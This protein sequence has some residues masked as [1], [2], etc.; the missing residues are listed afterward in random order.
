MWSGGTRLVLKVG[1]TK[2]AAMCVALQLAA[3]AGQIDGEQ[4]AEEGDSLTATAL[5]GHDAVVTASSGL[6][7]RS[8]PSTSN[9]VLLTMPHGAV[10]SV[11]DAQGAWYKVD[12]HGSVGWASASYLAE[13][14]GATPPSTSPSADA[15]AILDRARSGVGFSYHWGAGCWSPGSASP[16]ACYG[17][18]PNC[19][20]S[21]TWGADCS[22]FV[23]KAWQVPGA[24]SLET[25]QHPYSTVNFQNDRSHWSA[26]S[27]GSVKGADAF[28]YNANGAG[29]I[30]LYESG[31]GWGWVKAYEAKG[32]SYGIVYGT[33]MAASQY[34]A[35]RRT[36]L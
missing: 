24:S 26:V 11:T 6:N 27:R 34:S 7:L 29:H 9:A 19:T 20:H 18:C 14:P 33:R 10:V 16:G 5:V 12:F 13:V 28:V 8:G 35:I 2:L 4:T 31:D 36:G 22:G 15:G 17:S 23:A 1:M 25:C 21:G 32:C 30:F 3:C